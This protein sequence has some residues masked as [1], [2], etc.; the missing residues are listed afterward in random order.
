MSTQKWKLEAITPNSNG[1]WLEIQL[2]ENISRRIVQEFLD[3]VV[4]QEGVWQFR[5]I[6]V[7]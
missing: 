6:E 1:E 2:D 3:G 4:T 7:E 5:I